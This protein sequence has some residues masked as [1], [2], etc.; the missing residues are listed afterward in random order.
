MDLMI[1]IINIIFLIYLYKNKISAKNIFI[2]SA[3][4]NFYEQNY[5]K[6]YI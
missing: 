6:K 4:L 2:I 3:K 1:L 5:Y